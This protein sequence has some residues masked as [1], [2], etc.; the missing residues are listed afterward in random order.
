M[1]KMHLFPLLFLFLAV[2]AFAGCDT[3]STSAPDITAADDGADLIALQADVI[4]LPSYNLTQSDVAGL[5]HM[6]EEEK[7]ARDVYQ[8]F[9]EK[10][11]LGV[12]S[13]IATSEARHMAAVKTLLDKYGIADPVVSDA[14]G[15]FSDPAFTNLYAQLTAAGDKSLL[16]ALIVGATIED[17][18]IKDLMDLTA[19]TTAQDIQLVY[20]N[21]MRGSYNHLRAFSGQITANGGTYTPQ[22]ITQALYDSII[23]GRQGHN[24]RRW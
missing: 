15:T 14:R 6:R 13:N 21:I 20:G 17:L 22:Y 8:Y 12:F 2:S 7:L 11:N 23:A 5:I 24:G 18:D 19:A 16:D 4:A 10:Y 9:Y 1:N 3:T